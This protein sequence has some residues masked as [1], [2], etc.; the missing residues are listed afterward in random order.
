VTV[1]NVV[2]KNVDDAQKELRDQKLSSDV[3][4]VTHPTAPVDTVISQDPAAEETIDENS[5]VTLTVSAGAEAKQIPFDIVN[6]PV[7]EVTTTLQRLGFK[8]VAEDRPNDT[9]VKG[10]VVDSDPKPGNDAPIGSTVTLFV[11]SGPAPVAVPPV[12]GLQQEAAAEQLQ[13]AGFVVDPVSEAS[14]TV[15]AGTVTRTD[16][17]AGKEAPKG[18]RVRMFVST[19]KP[20]VAVPPVIGDDVD[21]ARAELETAGFTVSTLNVVDDTNVGKVLDQNPAA[22]TQAPKGSNVVLRVGIASGTA[23]TTTTAP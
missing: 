22:G 1:P 14:E 7:G 12:A 8:V 17:A 3:K 9:I 18:S 11:S 20:T 4:R 2:G 15:P 10:N 19:G 23:T 5:T 21:D 6:K 13:G 16:P